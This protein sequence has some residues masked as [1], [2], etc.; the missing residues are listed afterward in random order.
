[1]P[2][3][4]GLVTMFARVGGHGGQEKRGKRENKNFHIRP[5]ISENIA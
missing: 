1:M 4:I 2:V 5:E 3:F